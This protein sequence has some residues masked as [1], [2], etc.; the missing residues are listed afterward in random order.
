MGNHRASIKIEFRMHGVEDKTDMWINW[1]PDHTDCDP[2]IYEWFAEVAGRAL[3]KYEEQR[4]ERD[5]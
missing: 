5:D 3:A 4:R 1:S 2:R